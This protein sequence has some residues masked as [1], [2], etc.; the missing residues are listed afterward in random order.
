M[1]SSCGVGAQESNRY[2]TTIADRNGTS[3]RDKSTPKS[4]C[5]PNL[6]LNVIIMDILILFNKIL[7]R[8]R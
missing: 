6:H 7:Y 4:V 5:T 1:N 2:Y 3:V 8:I